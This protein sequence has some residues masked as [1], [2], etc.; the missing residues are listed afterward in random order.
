MKKTLFFGGL[1]LL[2]LIDETNFTFVV[3]IIPDFLL[4]QGVSLSLIGFI[5]SF[6]QISYFFASLYMGKR[7]MFYNKTHVMLLGQIGLILSNLALSFLNYGLSTVMI[8]VLSVLLRLFQGLALA[9]VSSGIYAYVHVLFPTDLDRKYAVLE[10]S[11]GCGLALGP[12]VGGFLYEYA[13]YTG[14]FITMT[15]VYAAITVILFPFFMKFKLVFENDSLNEE[16][17]P[18]EGEEEEK[19]EKTEPLQTRKILKNKNFLLTFWIFVCEYGCYNLI[20]PGFSAHVHDYDGSEDTVGMI[21]GLGDLTY[22]L[23]GFLLVRFLSKI[24]VRRKYLFLFGGLMSLISLL[25]LGPDDYT[26]LPKD[27]TT[28]S[29][30]M[31]VLGFAQMFYTATLI[32][33]YLDI[34]REMDPNAS[35]SE[36]LACGLFN[37]SVAGTEFIGV[38]LGGVLSDNFGFSRGMAIYAMYLLAVLVIFALFRKVSKTTTSMVM[39]ETVEPLMESQF[40]IDSLVCDGSKKSTN[41]EKDDF[42][43]SKKSTPIEKEDL[44]NDN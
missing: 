9:L 41:V 24:N 38:I 16:H 17:S 15:I 44:Y 36:E 7:L 30:G 39:V 31:G 33:E 27:L 11:L 20:Q 6:Y 42:Y 4:Q 13:E 29:I 37:A 26:F 23:T 12:V 14:A 43:R 8:I 5:L 28:V 25:I 19:I 3:P 32:P 35:G 40:N 1:C 18:K 2:L 21:F 10:I 22:A 34:F